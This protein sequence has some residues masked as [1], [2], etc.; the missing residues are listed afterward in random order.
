MLDFNYTTS[1]AVNAHCGPQFSTPLPLFPLLWSQGVRST[2]WLLINLAR[3][4]YVPHG[5]PLRTETEKERE[6]EGLT[7]V[8][9]EASL[10]NFENRSPRSCYRSNLVSGLAS[11][12]SRVPQLTF[13]CPR[14]GLKCRKGFCGEA[15]CVT[16]A[17][18]HCCQHRNMSNEII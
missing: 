11:R 18:N 14:M 1:E 4:L 16:H 8:C 12:L 15:A 13:Y 2:S 9:E 7:H 5:T 6:G 3:A 17:V 10:Y